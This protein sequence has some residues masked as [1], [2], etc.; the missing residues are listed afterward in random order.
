MFAQQREGAVLPGGIG[1]RYI[2]G[3]VRRLSWWFAV[4]LLWLT[5]EIKDKMV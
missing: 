3:A 2:D 4:P 5:K 1:L